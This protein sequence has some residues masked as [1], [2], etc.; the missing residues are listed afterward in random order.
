MG[1]G[2]EGY[3]VTDVNLSLAP[4]QPFYPQSG[5]TQTTSVAVASAASTEAA[6]VY[7]ATD[8]NGIKRTPNQFLCSNSSTTPAGF[9]F[10][11]GTNVAVATATS[12]HV[13][14]PAGGV[15]VVTLPG[16]PNTVATWGY[17]AGTGTATVTP[18]DGI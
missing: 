13:V 15:K 11:W 4:F 10:G 2:Q 5:Q 16:G 3:A 12:A 7:P 18:G 6:L 9:T 1:F 8:A 14:V 17:G